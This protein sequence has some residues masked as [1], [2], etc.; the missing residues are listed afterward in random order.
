LSGHDPA[1]LDA[2][3]A[4]VCRAGRQE[5]VCKTGGLERSARHHERSW[6][7]I[8]RGRGRRTGRA[9]KGAQHSRR[10]GAEGGEARTREEPGLTPAIAAG[11][12]LWLHSRPAVLASAGWMA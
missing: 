1:H 11:G 10:R 5:V 8:S 2:R 9:E 12:I 4:L 6:T 7:E 3:S